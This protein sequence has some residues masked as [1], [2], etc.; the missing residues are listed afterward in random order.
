IWYQAKRQ[1]LTSNQLYGIN[2]LLIM[3]GVQFLLGVL[4]IIY[5]VPVWLG[6]VHQVGAFFLLAAMTFTLH[7]FSK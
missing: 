1:I 6:V 3:V 5:A 7:R 2:A 4:T